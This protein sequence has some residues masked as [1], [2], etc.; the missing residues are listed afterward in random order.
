MS[1]SS[2][3][4]TVNCGREPN[5]RSY[6]ISLYLIMIEVMG[7][8][9]KKTVKT[10]I[11]VNDRGG[12]TGE[13]RPLS[14]V[15]SRFCHAPRLCY[16]NRLH[17]RRRNRT[18]VARRGSQSTKS[19]FFKILL[20]IIMSLKF[21]CKIDQQRSRPKGHKVLSASSYLL[22]NGNLVPRSQ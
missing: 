19:I 4:V 10:A 3:K 9:A 21:A 15:S 6:L 2:A 13:R 18:P 5:L 20:D 17:T 1:F 11:P 14:P 8:H 7:S 16:L 22:Q 12:K